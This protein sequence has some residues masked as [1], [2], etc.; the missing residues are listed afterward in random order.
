MEFKTTARVVI[1]LHDRW[2]PPSDLQRVMTS[3]G[4]C[5]V[6]R[7]DQGP[8][9]HPSGTITHVWYHDP[10]NVPWWRRR[11]DL[12]HYDDDDYV[13]THH[14]Y[15]YMHMLLLAFMLIHLIS[16][17]TL[18]IYVYNWCLRLCGVYH[19]LGVYVIL[20]VYLCLRT[21][22]LYLVCYLICISLCL[23][24]DLYSYLS[25]LYLNLDWVTI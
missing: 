4:Q 24:Y 6:L 10:S 8:L 16:A 3:W 17:S 2:S 9:S 23:I 20:I 21:I 25:Y 14:T 15:W 12:D 18:D 11:H 13:T 1:G 22:Y 19:N 5:S 7:L